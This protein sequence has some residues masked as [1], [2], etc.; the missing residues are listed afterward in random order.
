MVLDIQIFHLLNNLAGQSKFFDWFI[1]FFAD[2]LQYVL[3]VGFLFFIFYSAKKIKIF[4]VVVLSMIVSRY[5]IVELIRYFYHRPRPFMVYNINHLVANGSYSF[6]SGHA[7]LFFAMAMAI[8]FYNK[9]W[10]V[11]FFIAAALMGVARII[12]GV[13]YP[14][15]ILGGAMIGI[16]VAY[17]I[18]KLKQKYD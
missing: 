11:W 5:G 2:Y 3:V 9:K 8:Y 15:D 10:S 1:I 7:A 18:L 17:L 4:L 16:V 14:T 6:P 13:H 12:A